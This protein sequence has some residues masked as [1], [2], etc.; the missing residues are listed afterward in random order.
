MVIDRGNALHR[1]TKQDV[2]PEN[3]REQG[4]T[5]SDFLNAFNRVPGILSSDLAALDDFEADIRSEDNAVLIARKVGPAP[6]GH[7]VISSTKS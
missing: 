1:E 5:R 3:R 4:S 2:I 7:D 6:E